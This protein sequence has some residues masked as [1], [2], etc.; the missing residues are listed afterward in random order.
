M[1]AD[2]NRPAWPD[3]AH[4]A[5]DLE[6]HARLRDTRS[7]ADQARPTSRMM[8]FAKM[9]I[10][11]GTVYWIREA[12]AWCRLL[13]FC[14]MLPLPVFG[15]LDHIKTAAQML[16]QGQREQAEH[17]ARL[18]MGDRATRPLALAMLGSI[19][20]EEGRYQD[21]IEFLTQ[22]LKLNPNLSG[23]W[24]T[25]GDAYVLQNKPT[26]ASESF[27]KALKVD[28]SNGQA[29]YD[30]AKLESSLHHYQ[31][32]LDIAQPILPLL[33]KS[34]DGLLVLAADYGAMEH[35]DELARV[36]QAWQKLPQP[37]ADEASLELA[38][39]LIG[40]GMIPEAKALADAVESRSAGHLPWILAL[41]LGKIYMG[42]KDWDRAER[43]FE[44]ALSLN[45]ACA[46]CEEGLADVAER[47]GDTEKALADLLKAKQL[48]PEDPEVLFAFGK[49]CL[50]R[51]LI[52]DALSALGE[53]ASL[54]PDDDRYV[55]VFGSAN[56]A[57]GNL[58]KAA[59]LFGQLL[60]KHSNDPVLNYAMG[61]V[62][63]LQGKYTDAESAL[64]QSLEEQPDQVGAPYYLSL[65]YSHLG[66][67]NEAETL[68]HRLVKSHPQYAPPYVKLGT[69]LTTQHNYDEA[70]T[71]LERAIAL[72]SSS[73]EAHYQ[74][75]VLFKSLG[76]P[77]EAQQHF[78]EWQ[79]LQAEQKARK[80]LELHLL[81]PE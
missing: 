51:D 39:L 55:Y 54:K 68:L 18:A 66:Q 75:Y 11:A 47:Q 41:N 58:P 9:E 31:K 8:D 2:W 71:Y 57:R 22:A 64:K 32:S 43:D 20:L 40:C 63:Y 60:H 72:D 81:L 17:E 48:A 29:R 74:L 46:A 19:R 5:V 14:S 50:K 13:V 23:T 37:P 52:E 53:A 7:G 59:S 49:I 79:K 56:V 62:Y 38:R 33:L 80:H 4:R 69:I 42:L 6:R 24:T 73:P 77:D 34:D 1:L 78:T 21:S 26:L 36:V 76:K 67:N 65:T 25:L 15:Q 12:L 30:L 45:P 16:D 3:A 35:K 28:P 61:T 70:Q 10:A 44:L 27:E